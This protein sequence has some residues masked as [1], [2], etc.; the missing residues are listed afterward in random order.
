MAH[1][2]YG[3]DPLSRTIDDDP[4]VNLTTIDE[5]LRDCEPIPPDLAAW[6]GHAIR[7]SNRDPKEFMQRLGLKKRRG[8]QPHKHAH[9]AW[10]EW[11]R[12]VDRREA[13]LASAE[14]ALSEVIA[15][16]ETVTG[17]EVERSQLQS[18]RDKYRAALRE[19]RCQ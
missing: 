2:E 3:F 18:W 7:F 13:E 15:E 11:G 19:S 8:R 9:D 5:Y 16:Y 1:L 14:G 12:R 10:L 17:V 6:L 4:W